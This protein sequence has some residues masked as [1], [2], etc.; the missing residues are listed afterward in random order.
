M[1][2]VVKILMERDEL[3]EQE[4]IDLVNECREEILTSGNIWEAE[5]IIADYLGLELDYIM[6]II[7]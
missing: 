2:R 5:D 7:L 1:N 4:A 3:T 6:D